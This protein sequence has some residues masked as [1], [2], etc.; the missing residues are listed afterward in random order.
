MEYREIHIDEIV[1]RIRPDWPDVFVDF[2][3]PIDLKNNE[4]YKLTKKY[5]LQLEVEG[6]TIGYK[7]GKYRL[8]ETPTFLAFLNKQKEKAW[9]C[10]V[11]RHKSDCG[12]NAENKDS[13]TITKAKRKS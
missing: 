11:R 13:V 6:E 2:I 4:G 8:M 5:D 1:T 3:Y 7:P 12:M 9:D 10:I